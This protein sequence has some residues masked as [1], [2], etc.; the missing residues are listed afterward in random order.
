MSAKKVTYEEF[1]KIIGPMDVTVAVVG[2]RHPYKSVF[3][4]RKG[5]TVGWE[6]PNGEL[7]LKTTTGDK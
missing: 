6:E 2:D 1:Y 4:T 3:K 5:E 7:Y